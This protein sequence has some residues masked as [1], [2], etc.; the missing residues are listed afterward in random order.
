MTPIKKREE[1]YHEF[2][3]PKP[4]Y[5]RGQRGGRGVEGRAKRQ[6]A[7]G[8]AVREIPADGKE[9]FIH[10]FIFIFITGSSEIYFLIRFRLVW[11]SDL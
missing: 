7:G 2:L 3:R 11:L 8:R 10:L 1:E 9:G 6:R 4:D 5:L